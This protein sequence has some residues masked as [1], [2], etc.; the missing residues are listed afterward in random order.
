[1]SRQNDVDS[2]MAFTEHPLTDG[3]KPFL[4]TTMI[5]NDRKIHSIVPIELL[6][7]FQFEETPALKDALRALCR[8]FIDILD[9]VKVDVMVTK[10]TPTA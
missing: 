4:R 9:T 3:S 6:A 8:E 7:M 2:H 1:M 5:S 10:Q